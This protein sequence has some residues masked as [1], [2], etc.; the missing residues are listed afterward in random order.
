MLLIFNFTLFLCRRTSLSM[1]SSLSDLVGSP[2]EISMD[3]VLTIEELRQHMGSCFT[4]GVSWTDDH[5]SLDCSECGGYSVERPCPLCDGQCGVQWKRDFTMVSCDTLE[6]YKL[7]FLLTFLFFWHYSHMPAVKL[8]GWVCV[9]LIPKQLP[10]LMP[11]PLQPPPLQMPAIPVPLPV[12]QLL[13]LKCV[14]PQSCVPAWNSYRPRLAHQQITYESMAAN[15]LIQ[16]HHPRH[17]RHT[18]T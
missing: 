7:N 4:C 9:P 1:S 2:L 12:L 3:N 10:T 6:H 13:P 5:V 16:E 17:W 11:P 18:H 15:I 8:V 14:W